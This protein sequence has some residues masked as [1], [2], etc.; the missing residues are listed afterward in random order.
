MN[1]KVSN[2]TNQNCVIC[3]QSITDKDCLAYPQNS[4]SSVYRFGDIE[5]ITTF[6]NQQKNH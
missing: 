4:L 1:Y 5:N 6:N 3:Y 2:C